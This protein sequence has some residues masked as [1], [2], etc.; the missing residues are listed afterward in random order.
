M[1][2]PQLLAD[3]GMNPASSLATPLLVRSGIPA[4]GFQ[5]PNLKRP[6]ST[7]RPAGKQQ[8]LIPF[9]YGSPL[10]GMTFA[11]WT[12]LILV[13]HAGLGW[14]LRTVRSSSLE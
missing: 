8:N 4:V 14:I 13:I 5:S 12:A 10:P 2:E 6:F 7:N 3:L 9:F 11:A 1:R